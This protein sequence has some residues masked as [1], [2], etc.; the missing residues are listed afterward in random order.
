MIMTADLVT[1][2]RSIRALA[3][4]A[5]QIARDIEGHRH[6]VERGGPGEA[7]SVESPHRTNIIHAPNDASTMAIAQIGQYCRDFCTVFTT[8]FAAL[9]PD[10]QKAIAA[11]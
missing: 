3:A 2:I 6:R 5:D 4:R 10:L 9:P 1:T 11:N 7:A 8:A